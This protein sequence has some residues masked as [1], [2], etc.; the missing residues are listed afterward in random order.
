MSENSAK[1][2]SRRQFI[3]ITGGVVGAAALVSMGLKFDLVENV[4]EI[5]P[6]N[7]TAR[8]EETDILVIGGGMAGL[9]A[10]VKGHDAGSRVHMVVKGR[11]GTSGETPFAKGMFSYDPATAVMDLDEYLDQI[12]ASALNTN[13]PVFTR[14]M[15]V[16]SQ[17]RVK[18]LKEW[19]FFDSPP[20]SRCLCEAHE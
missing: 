6:E 19:G 2:I 4:R 9:F 1:G 12:A 20:L 16:N 10:A 13:N 17:A 14:Q 5:D 3:G 18:E 7:M 8:E 11:L 15:T